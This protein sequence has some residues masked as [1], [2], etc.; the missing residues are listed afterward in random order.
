MYCIFYINIFLYIFCGIT[1]TVFEIVYFK[2]FWDDVQTVYCSHYCVLA[3][4]LFPFSSHAADVVS[5]VALLMSV[6]LLY[7]IHAMQLM[8]FVC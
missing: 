1:V 3:L 2:Y 6:L 5:F 4:I 7:C 8:L